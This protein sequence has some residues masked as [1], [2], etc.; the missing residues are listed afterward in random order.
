MLCKLRALGLYDRAICAFLGGGRVTDGVDSNAYDVAVMSGGFAQGHLPVDTFEEIVRV[1]KPGKE[2]SVQN[3]R[4][5]G[6]NLY[7]HF[8]RSFYPRH[9]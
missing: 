9:D 6:Y 1:V 7:S 8:R 5:W 2:V 3:Y 4:V